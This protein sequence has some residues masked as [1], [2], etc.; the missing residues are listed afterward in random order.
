[1]GRGGAGPGRGQAGRGGAGT[2]RG[3]AGRSVAGTGRGQ[4]GR[5]G[6]GRLSV[7]RQGEVGREQGV[8]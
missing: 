5:G 8:V 1:M 6:A 7:V 2:G 3:Q 4:A